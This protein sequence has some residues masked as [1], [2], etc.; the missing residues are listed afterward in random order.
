MTER[1]YPPFARFFTS[2]LKTLPGALLYFYE[3]GTTTPKIV[4][5]DV[6][7]TTPHANPV[8]AGTLGAGA[9][10]FPAIFL[11]GTYAVELKNAAGVTQDGW[12]QNNVGGEQVEGQFDSYSSITNYTIGRIVSGSDGQFYQ[13]QSTPNLNRD[14]VLI[15]NR[16]TYWV[17][18]H[19]EQEYDP[20]ATYEIGQQVIYSGLEYVAVAQTTGNTPASTSAFWKLAAEFFAWNASTTYASGAAVYVGYKKYIS[21]QN[22]N[23]NHTPA[24]AGDTCIAIPNSTPNGWNVVHYQ[25]KDLAPGA[26]DTSAS[27]VNLTGTIASGVTGVTQSPGDNSTK[28]ATTAYADAAVAA[29]GSGESI[30]DVDASVGSNALTIT[31][32][33]QSIKFRSTTLTDGTP[34]TRT[35]ASPITMTVSSGSTLG[36]ISGVQSDILIVAIDNAGTVEVACINFAGNT[37]VSETGLISTTAEGGAGAADS[38]TVFYST[39]ARSD[40]AYRVVGLIRSTQATAGTWATTLSLVQGKGGNSSFLMMSVGYGRSV[41]FTTVATTS[42]TTAEFTGIPSTAKKLTLMFNGQGNATT[43]AGNRLIQLGD[44]GGYETTGYAGEDTSGFS[45]GVVVLQPTYGHIQITKFSP[46]AN[47]WVASGNLVQGF[48][49]GDIPVAGSKT[50][51]ATLDRIRINNPET[52]NAG[53]IG[54]MVE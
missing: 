6:A 51:S 37:D 35:I 20:G 45:F 23:L 36:T 28:I 41:L 8:V 42:G 21:Q 15:A 11:D 50:L 22:T 25:R 46:T 26:A 17:Q 40:V 1:F 18:L 24:D 47:T 30:F 39:T 10:Q 19:L 32:N 38:A 49:W 48:N 29:A 12:P 53:S 4:Y 44:S 34:V 7:K 52:M 14:P 9:D 13:S 2:D 5:Q 27:S 3:N 54:L 16:P 43:N 31:I 33:A